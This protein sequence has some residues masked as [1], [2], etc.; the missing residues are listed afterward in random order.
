MWHLYVNIFLI[1][2]S[3]WITIKVEDLANH[4]E[5]IQ[6]SVFHPSVTPPL[7]CG[8]QSHGGT[9][10]LQSS[11]SGGHVAHRGGCRYPGH[12]GALSFQLEKEGS[13]TGSCKIEVPS[14]AP[15][16]RHP[17]KKKRWDTESSDVTWILWQRL[18]HSCLWFPLKTYKYC[19]ITVLSLHNCICQA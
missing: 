13:C 3:C 11:L 5:N 7:L 4:V 2:A 19:I 12:T 16:I 6:V 10:R 17:F 8:S 18:Q 14:S 15:Y 1:L 9:A